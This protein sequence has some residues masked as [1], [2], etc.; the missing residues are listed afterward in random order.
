MH[1]QVWYDGIVYQCWTCGTKATE[2]EI[3]NEIRCDKKNEE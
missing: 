2:P 3:L 1:T